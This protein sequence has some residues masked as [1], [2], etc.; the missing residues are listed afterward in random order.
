MHA[1]EGDLEAARTLVHT[2]PDAEL[3]VTPATGT[4]SPMAACL[5][6]TSTLRRF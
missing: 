4:C 3:F 6:T 2:T 1:A 5:P